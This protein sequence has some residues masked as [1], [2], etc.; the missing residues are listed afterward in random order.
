MDYQALNLVIVRDKF[1][2]PTIDKLLDELGCACW[3]S[4]L[5]LCQGFHQIRVE[6]EDIPKTT[7]RTHHGHY[8]FCVMPFGLCNAPSTFRTTMNELLKPFFRK[9]ATVFFDDILGYNTSLPGHLDHLELILQALTNGEFYLCH[10][11]CLFARRQLQY[12]GHI[13]STDGV[14]PDLKKIQTMVNWPRPS[15]TTK[16]REFLGLTGFYRRFIK[17]YAS[18]AGPLNALL[19]KDQFHWNYEAQN[20][21]EHLKTLMTQ[22]SILATPD[23]NLPFIL[24]T[25]ASGIAMG[26]VLLQ[27]LH[28]IAYYNKPF[29]PRL[30]KASM[31]VRELHAIT[32]AIRKWCHYLLGH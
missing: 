22:V 13:V 8:E 5:D 1:P 17:T 12:L 24:E 30:Q 28:P 7:F 16:L 14:A 10:S 11:K 27:Q 9:F 26:V 15:S 19:C 18:I 32:A 4:K 20:A 25:D 21:F 6:K 23:F 3:F 2:M 31:Y 29:C